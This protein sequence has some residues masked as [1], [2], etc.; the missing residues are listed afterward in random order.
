MA[1]A[2]SLQNLL[3]DVADF[4]PLHEL[5]KQQ[6]Q[7]PV[8]PLII[9]SR[10]V[11]AGCCFVALQGHQIDARQFVNEAVASGAALILA[12]AENVEVFLPQWQGINVPVIL[13]RDLAHQLSQ[14]A[15]NY[16]QHPSRALKVFAVTGTNGK[17][18][19]S[20]MLARALQHLHFDCYL[21]GTLGTGR[22]SQMQE[23]AN[24]TAD[25]VT[26][27]R[28]LAEAVESGAQFAAMEV[29]S[30]ALVQGRAKALQINTALFT[31]LTHDHLDY[32]G[33]MADY[34]AAKR[35]LFLQP[36]LKHAVLNAD[37]KYGRK[38]MRDEAI[39]AKKWM[40]STDTPP[41]GADLSQ[42]IWAEDISFSDKGIHAV[43][44]SPWGM[45]RLDSPLMGQFNLN[46]LLLIIAS[47]GALCRSLDQVL[48]ALSQVQAP[49]GRMQKIGGGDNQPLVIVDYA[50]T[51]DALQQTLTA[52]REHNVGRIWCVF[53]C[54]GDRD[55]GKRPKMARV[56]E[57]FA[58]KVIVTQDNPRTE[59]ETQ[60][61]ADIMAGFHDPD[62]VQCIA[63]RKQ[64]IITAINNARPGDVVLI[65]GKG[66]EDYQIVGNN[67]LH[68]SDL[69]EAA[70]ALEGHA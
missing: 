65:A 28:V 2:I 27:Q 44:N 20:Y 3:D 46:N 40:V 18:S 34:F 45:G 5:S 70:A 21:L 22:F 54:G 38:L 42:W 23:Q 6:W 53:G 14:I 9:D 31:N 60:I 39:T 16:Y 17:T 64:A 43:I 49:P 57:Q 41:E 24:T 8:G 33:S 56:A 59:S 4:T 1:S 62:K 69:E 13:V 55:K 66:H 68:F 63:D 52:L 30:H 10:K 61:E 25:A 35:Q 58:N 36:G 26:L 51:P 47:L 50:H 11:Q 67:K 32:H 15:G 29:S 12:E 37:D 48:M 19:C 7:Q